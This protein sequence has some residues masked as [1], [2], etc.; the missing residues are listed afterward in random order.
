MGYKGK[1]RD[2]LGKGRIGNDGEMIER[3]L[4]DMRRERQ[5]RIWRGMV[6]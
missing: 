6:G 3:V 4:T 5:G 2:G 1:A